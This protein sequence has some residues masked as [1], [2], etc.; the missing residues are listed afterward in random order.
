MKLESYQK[1]KSLTLAL[2]VVLVLFLLSITYASAATSLYTERNTL[3]QQ[4]T[5]STTK[6]QAQKE[7]AAVL[8]KE[9]VALESQISYLNNK[10]SQTETE[11]SASSA[12]VEQTRAEI[13]VEEQ[14]LTTAKKKL[15][16][17]LSDW[18]MKGTP[19]F[20]ET[21]IS[22]GK[23]SQFIDQAQYY[24]ALRTQIS[25]N[26]AKVKDLKISL[27]NTKKDQEKQLADLMNLN[28]TQTTQKK[29][30]ANSQANKT[31]MAKISDE[32]SSKYAS[33]ASAALTKLTQVE[34]EIRN[35]ELAAAQRYNSGNRAV[36]TRDGRSTQGFIWP[37]IGEFRAG[38]GYSSAYFSGM[39]HTGVDI[40]AY[41]LAPI[42]AAKAGTVVD[43]RD[44]NGNT[45]PWSKS[46]GNYAKIQHEGGVYSLYG[47][48][49]A[50]TI[51]VSKGQSVD[52]GQVI[53]QEG[54]SGFS[55]GY[56]LHFELRGPD[57]IAFDPAPYLP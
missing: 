28:N 34:G 8:Q 23:L 36:W 45:Y 40:G 29:S 17:V 35:Q 43:V 54:N 47:H 9:A 14:N 15:G 6:S 37:L 13:V 44:G 56:H 39:F 49:E 30:K 48:L 52:Q 18:Y 1:I 51:T 26:I 42:K 20:S 19:S 16:D 3:K 11:I 55:T 57:D 32:L 10:I 27:E 4:A 53:G 12:Q 7:Q 2:V 22:S 25:D 50:G 38:F 41:P 31:Q 24:E 46:Y 5:T 21:I 33:E